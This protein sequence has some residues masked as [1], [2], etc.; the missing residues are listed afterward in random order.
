MDRREP[1]M[2]AEKRYE[3]AEIKAKLMEEFENS[4]CTGITF[5]HQVLWEL[6]EAKTLLLIFEKR[7]HLGRSNSEAVNVVILLTEYQ[8]YQGADLIFTHQ[9]TDQ[10]VDAVVRA[11]KNL[12]FAEGKPK[13]LFNP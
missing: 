3:P 4:P 10:L 6:G 13:P 8:G 1:T 9:Y 12:G 5:Q 7:I 2:Y 11:M